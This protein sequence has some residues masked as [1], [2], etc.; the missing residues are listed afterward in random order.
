[1]KLLKKLNKLRG[2]G[3]KRN[4]M[5]IFPA[6]IEKHSKDVEKKLEVFIVQKNAWIEKQMKVREDRPNRRYLQGMKTM[7][8]MVLNFI[9]G[10][11]GTV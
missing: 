10:E 7:S 11:N 9:K 3:L 2:L 6:P 4:D 8:Y 5:R 1:M